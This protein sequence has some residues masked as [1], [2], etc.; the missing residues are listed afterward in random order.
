MKLKSRISF[1]PPARLLQ[2][3]FE[4]GLAIGK[5]IASEWNHDGRPRMTMGAIVLERH[6]PKYK[7]LRSLFL[8]RVSGV[9]PGLIKWREVPEASYSEAELEQHE[10]LALHINGEAG[11]GGNAYADVYELDTCPSCGLIRIR[12]QVRDLVVDLSKARKDFASTLNFQEDLVS[13]RLKVMLVDAQVSGVE[14]RPVHHAH[15]SRRI[16]RQYFQLIIRNILKPMA[17]P[18]HIYANHCDRCG[19]E[20]NGIGVESEKPD[21]WTEIN[22]WGPGPWN[23]MH[24]PRSSYHS[25]DL[26]RTEEVFGGPPRFSGLLVNQRLFRLLRRHKITGFWVQPAHLDPVSH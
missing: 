24:F 11:L 25:W 20:H 4:R 8:R 21:P 7:A 14:F 12:S 9:E 23:E 6:S 3:E 19:Y 26:M 1:T 5:E 10:I 2:T 17:A 18:K 15:P 13:S 16:A 22:Y